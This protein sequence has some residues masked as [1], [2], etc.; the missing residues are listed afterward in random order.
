MIANMRRR[1][2]LVP[3]LAALVVVLSGC[4]LFIADG[5]EAVGV[6]SKGGYFYLVD[7]DSR[8][9]VMLDRNLA[10]RHSWPFSDFTT[11]TAL[12]GVTF[13]GAALWV[14]IAGGVDA[15]LQLDLA[16]D[17]GATVVR[18]LPAPPTGQ[19]TVRDIAWDGQYMWALNSGSTTY[20]VPPTLYKL[21]PADGA[22]VAQY[23]LPSSE[24]RG[25]C[26]V[27]PNTDVYGSG[28]VAGCYYTDKDDDTIHIFET[29]RAVFHPGF[30]APVGPRGVN[31][32]YPVGLAFDG[33][34]FWS[35]NSSGLADYLFE[36]DYTGV[37][38]Q[39]IDPPYAQM[40]ALV[41]AATDLSVPAAPVVG[42]VSPNTGGPRARKTVTVTGSGFRAGLTASF[43]AGVVVDSLTVV[44]STSLTVY[45]SIDPAAALGA[46]DVTV[47]NSDGQ[48][49]VGAGLFNVVDVDPSTGYL[50]IADSAARL[51]YRYSI[52]D[53]VFVAAYST[54]TVAPGGSVQGLAFDGTR[55]WVAAAG[56]DDF[57]AAIDTTGGTLSVT[58]NF[59]APPAGAG[60]VRDMA[61]DGTDL[62]VP[63][64][65]T[66]SVYR[67]S[68]DDGAV[69]ATIAAPSAGIRGT[70]WANGH[71][72]CND[73]D[74]DTVYMWD[75][76]TSTWS[77]VFQT[78]VPP[79][80]TTA[81]R[82]ATG[83]TWDGVSFW[84]VNS[85]GEFDYIFQVAP[86][87]TVLRTVEVPGRGTA[88][89]TGLA[90]SQN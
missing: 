16:G 35:T 49:G 89:P 81:N 30:A 84:I 31:Y 26:Y 18:T 54:A 67:V 37:V 61:F 71:L 82:F 20:A 70:T 65:G 88:T 47:T 8:R 40:G 53:G 69:L 13:D 52:N 10:E 43:G 41:W 66:T 85:T 77:A 34:D 59:Q 24:P 23:P 39:R 58:T 9:L 78:P 12:Q 79:G 56:T 42:Q 3:L 73:K 80:G 51:L 32:V 44:N 46:R 72:Y 29:A 2:G 6:Q 7:N 28:A 86:D 25:M 5:D 83:M 19:G 55:L 68:R 87:G 14:S 60:T 4:H 90:F 38:K 75:A 15:I 1:V 64:D 63:N 45:I 62:W 33:T 74:T 50:W 22:I 11:E 21:N 27:G 36:M 57:I 48:S 17:A 76:G